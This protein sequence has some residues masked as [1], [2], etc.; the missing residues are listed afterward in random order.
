MQALT[1]S[2]YAALL[3]GAWD[4]WAQGAAQDMDLEEGPSAVAVLHAV[5]DL[6][7]FEIVKGAAIGRVNCQRTCQTVITVSVIHDLACLETAEC[8]VAMSGWMISRI[9]HTKAP[10]PIDLQTH[11]IVRASSCCNLSWLVQAAAGSGWRRTRD[12]CSS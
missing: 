9:G 12:T 4:C 2:T 6:A 11:A 8:D 10:Q 3:A 5:Q 1:A 7:C